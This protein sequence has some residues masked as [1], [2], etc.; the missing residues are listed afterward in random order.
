MKR[1]I[2]LFLVAALLLSFLP[3]LALQA[4]AVTYIEDVFVSPGNYRIGDPI[5]EADEIPVYAEGGTVRSVSGF[6]NEADGQ[7]ATG[8]FE[9]NKKYSE[10]WAMSLSENDQKNKSEKPY[11]PIYNHVWSV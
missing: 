10:K 7:P 3:G 11:F 6:T 8:V 2:C 4:S 5:P 1:T 9:K